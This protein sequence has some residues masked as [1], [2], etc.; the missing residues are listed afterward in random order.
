MD[1]STS[2]A[3]ALSSVNAA[4]EMGRTFIGM[5]DAHVTA[6]AQREFGEKL[7]GAQAHLLEIGAAAIAQQGQIGVL[8]ERV[9]ELEAHAAEKQRYVLAEVSAG[10][11]FFAY[12]LRNA[13]ELQERADEA[14]HF[15][16]Q[17]CFDGGQKAVLVGNGSGT[18][19]CPLC[20]FIARPGPAAAQS[21]PTGGRRRLFSGA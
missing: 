8:A 14:P 3:S 7:A 17:P 1:V 5:R 2:I 15:V 11:E 12:R 20:K 6:A 21:A 16:C 10:R 18:W 4:L 19:E 13:V 9:R